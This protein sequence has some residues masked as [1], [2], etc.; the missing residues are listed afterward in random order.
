[1]GMLHVEDKRKA[2]I[3]LG[4]SAVSV[5]FMREEGCA[6]NSREVDA[7]L[8]AAMPASMPR[9]GDGRCHCNDAVH[10]LTTHSHFQQPRVMN[11]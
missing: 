1:M 11:N 5:W 9:Q 10:S 7:A 6:I 4:F 8:D 2:R 3:G